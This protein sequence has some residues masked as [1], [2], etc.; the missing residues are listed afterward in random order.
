MG[1]TMKTLGEVR[2]S[3]NSLEVLFTST[4]DGQHGDVGRVSFRGGWAPLRLIL[5]SGSALKKVGDGE[6]LYRGQLVP[7]GGG[8]GLSFELQ[9]YVSEALP[10]A[11]QWLETGDLSSN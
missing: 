3:R 6:Y 5:E 7:P 8:E 10:S 2:L 4:I 11:D 1:G 9:F